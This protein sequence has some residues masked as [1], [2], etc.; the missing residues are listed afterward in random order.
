MT[1][2]HHEHHEHVQHDHD[3]HT[4]HRAIATDPV[5]GMQVDSH[6]AKHCAEHDEQ[7]YYFCSRCHDKFVAEPDIYRA[8]KIPIE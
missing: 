2:E 1:H 3:H 6:T 8:G 7:T 5:C 4:N